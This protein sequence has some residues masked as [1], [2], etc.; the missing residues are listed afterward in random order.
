LRRAA[1]QLGFAVTLVTLCQFQA[2]K[3]RF[4]RVTGRVTAVTLVTSVTL[5]G[6]TGTPEDG[7]FGRQ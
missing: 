4:L 7:K 2:A 6:K 3:H 5:F 1:G